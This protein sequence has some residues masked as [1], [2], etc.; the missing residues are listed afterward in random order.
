MDRRGSAWKKVVVADV[1]PD[2]P[3]SNEN[4]LCKLTLRSYEFCMAQ[5][6]IPEHFDTNE[7][8]NI[9]IS[10]GISGERE[11]ERERERDGE[12]EREREREFFHF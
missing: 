9:L 7:G 10:D 8:L 3:L 1:V 11:S 12:R 5:Y 2:F 6:N 4:N